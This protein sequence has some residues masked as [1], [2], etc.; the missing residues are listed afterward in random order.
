MLNS[1]ILLGGLVSV[2][3]LGA[4][5]PIQ[6]KQDNQQIRLENH[7]SVQYDD[8]EYQIILSADE[9]TYSFNNFHDFIVNTL[10][11]GVL[12][13]NYKGVD[14][15]GGN[16]YQTMNKSEGVYASSSLSYQGNFAYPAIL[17][18][19]S[20]YDTSIYEFTSNNTNQFTYNAFSAE[21]G[22]LLDDV[23]IIGLVSNGIGFYDDLKQAIELDIQANLPNNDYSPILG[24]I[25]SLL[26]GGIVGLSSGLGAGVSALVGDIFIN[27]GSLSVF[28]YM[29]V[30]FA[31]IALAIGLSRWVMNFL[32]SLGAKK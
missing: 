21:N 24:D 20:N 13:F 10:T 8:E 23:L 18:N 9:V 11:N 32:T 1:I 2:F 26:T 12:T 25:V 4:I 6:E 7:K 22:V 27:N 29:V 15:G 5:N 16:R 14:F 3:G 17:F 28:G 31:G 30:I 19:T